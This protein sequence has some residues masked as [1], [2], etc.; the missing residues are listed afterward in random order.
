MRSPP[1]GSEEKIKAIA[2]DVRWEITNRLYPWIDGKSIE[3]CSNASLISLVTA[4]APMRERIA[5]IM[6][7]SREG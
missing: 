2:Q 7:A 3:R 1:V 5:H 6:E 4:L